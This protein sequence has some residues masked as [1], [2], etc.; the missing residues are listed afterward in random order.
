[1]WKLPRKVPGEQQQLHHG[2]AGGQQQQRQLGG[3][4]RG[5]EHGH[6][7]RPRRPGHQRAAVH[8]GLHRAAQLLLPTRG[9]RGDAAVAHGDNSGGGYSDNMRRLFY[10]R[11][12][13]RPFSKVL[14]CGIGILSSGLSC[15]PTAKSTFWHCDKYSLYYLHLSQHIMYWLYIISTKCITSSAKLFCQV[16]FVSDFRIKIHPFTFHDHYIN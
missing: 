2:H 3:G 4:G 7:R 8:R 5:G 12:H 1:M 6:A 10:K 16:H 14:K 9:E 15:H 11:Q 13:T